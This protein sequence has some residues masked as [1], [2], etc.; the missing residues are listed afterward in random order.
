[1][2][3]LKFIKIYTCNFTRHTDEYLLLRLYEYLEID[4]LLCGT[5]T[6]GKLYNFWREYDLRILA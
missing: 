5:L 4:L 2:L 3:R 1:M 6:H